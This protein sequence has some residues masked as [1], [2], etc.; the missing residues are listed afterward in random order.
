MIVARR[1]ETVSSWPFDSVL[2][3]TMNSQPFDIVARYI[4]EE[5]NT[6]SFFEI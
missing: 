2:K 5:L 1:I 4:V 6:D 3:G